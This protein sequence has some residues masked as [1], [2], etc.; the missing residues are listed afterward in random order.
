MS[1]FLGDGRL[2]AALVGLCVVGRNPAREAC[3]RQHA[4]CSCDHRRNLF[5]SR[6]VAIVT[7]TVLPFALTLWRRLAGGS[8]SRWV[9]AR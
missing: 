8:G 3:G 7:L 6:T 1:D 4:W 5:A 9:A 2:L